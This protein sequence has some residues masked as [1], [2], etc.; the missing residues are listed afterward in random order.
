MTDIFKTYSLVACRNAT[1]H[2]DA[3]VDWF[4]VLGVEP[5]AS[6]RDIRKAYRKRALENHPDKTANLPENLRKESTERF[7]LC[8]RAY[9]ILS[10][11]T[12]RQQFEAERKQHL[13]NPSSPVSERPT[14]PTQQRDHLTVEHALE[15]LLHFVVQC[16]K[17][18]MEQDR[19]TTTAILR[20]AAIVATGAAGGALHDM[21][22]AAI[23]GSMTALVTS[24]HGFQTEWSRLSEEDQSGVV[25]AFSVLLESI[26]VD[27]S[28]STRS[29]DQ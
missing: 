19:E 7:K 8:G 27:V 10:D 15:V 6:D 5:T 11:S 17:Q 16:V 12:L 23:M 21:R 25:Q 3:F 2:T 9:E 4:Q 18:Q 28:D 1:Q 24:P 14:S 22:L 13:E 20:L 29:T 26:R